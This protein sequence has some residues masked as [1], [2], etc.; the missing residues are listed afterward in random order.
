M[1]GLGRLGSILGPL[2]AGLLVAQGWEVSR[3]YF[4]MA[5]PALLAAGLM[6]LLIQEI[7]CRRAGTERIVGPVAL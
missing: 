5:V 4:A 6:A 1:L 7:D 2:G 3:I